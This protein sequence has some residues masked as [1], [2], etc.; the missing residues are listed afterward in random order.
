[1]ARFHPLIIRIILIICLFSHGDKMTFAL[2]DEVKDRI[3]EVPLVTVDKGARSGI[4]ERQFV[5][6][7]SEKEWESLWALHKSRVSPAPQVP[8][9][10]FGGEM[11]VAVFSG[12]KRTG[13]FGIEIRKIEEDRE[14]NR[15]AV[16]YFE[17]Q[18]P[19]R[20]MVIQALTQPYH[21]VRLRKMDLPAVF[22]A[23]GILPP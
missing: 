10:D 21:I 20:S 16:F 19:P 11:I 8:P 2:S 4:R 14:K 12:E 9:V 17:T 18:P 6:I 23:E 3:A 1:M 5:I 13:G 15:V 22:V 7:K